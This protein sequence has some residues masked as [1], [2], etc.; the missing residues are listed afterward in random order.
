MSCRKAVSGWAVWYDIV[1]AAFPGTD[2]LQIDANGKVLRA[3]LRKCKAGLQ[4]KPPSGLERNSLPV[5]YKPV[6]QIRNTD[7]GATICSLG[8]VCDSG[9][10]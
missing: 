9:T 4:G 8:R 3:L 5:G 2:F 6:G 10:K 1:C 7:N